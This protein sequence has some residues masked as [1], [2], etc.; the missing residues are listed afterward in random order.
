MS[1]DPKK[2]E[3]VLI[4]SGNAL[5]MTGA[6]WH[7]WRR[8]SAE[9]G[10]EIIAAGSKRFIVGEKLREAI[11]RHAKSKEPE[12]VDELAAMRERIARAG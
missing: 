11:E 12:V 1:S 10:L 3:A 8:H 4:S 9:L 5:A 7:Y 2:P 6:P